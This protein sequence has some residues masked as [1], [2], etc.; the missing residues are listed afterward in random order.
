MCDAGIA[1]L[2]TLCTGAPRA[3]RQKVKE[4]SVLLDKIQE[5]TLGKQTAALRSP[6]AKQ[7]EET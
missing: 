7:A 4:Q 1:M 6:I 2:V 5:M 3:H